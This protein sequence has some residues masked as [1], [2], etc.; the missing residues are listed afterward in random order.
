MDDARTE[1]LLS[2][3]KGLSVLLT[4]AECAARQK[5]RSND[6]AN[7]RINYKRFHSLENK[8]TYARHADQGR[9]PKIFFLST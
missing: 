6:L 3:S 8:Q 4:R 5:P 9:N 2:F 7:Q 1:L